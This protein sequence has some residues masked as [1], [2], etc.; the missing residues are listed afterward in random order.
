MRFQWSFYIK[1]VVKYYLSFVFLLEGIPK[2][3]ASKACDATKFE[4]GYDLMGGDI[5]P[6]GSGFR[7]A[8]SPEDCCNLCL[9]TKSCN[10]FTYAPRPTP[11]VAGFYKHNCWLKSS[12]GSLERNSDRISGSCEGPM[13]PAP[14][15]PAPTPDACFPHPTQPWC[16]VSLSFEARVEALINAMTTS[17]KVQQVS[18][19]TPSTVPGISRIGLPPYSYHSEGLHGLRD[20]V[21]TVGVPC[22]IFPQTTGMAATGNLSLIFAMGGIMLTEARALANDAENKSLGPFG[23]GAGLFYWSPTMNLGR[24]PRWGRFQESISED[25]FLNGIYSAIFVQAF[26]GSKTFGQPSQDKYL[27]VAAT[28]KHFIAYSLEASDGFSRHTFDAKVPWRDMVETYLPPFRMCISHGQP[29]QIMCSYNSI[30]GTPSCLH[31]DLLN[32]IARGKW[33]FDGL[34]VSDQDSISDSYKTH[35][36]CH[37]SGPNASALAI[38]A[39]CDQND[40]VTY[41]QNLEAALNQGLLSEKEL[42][43][44]L[45]RIL[46][47]RF[48]VGAFDPSNVV[49]P[50][51]NIGL[52]QVA[53]AS[54]MATSL[55]AAREAIVLLANKD[56]ILPFTKQKDVKIA[57]IGPFANYS[58]ALYGGKPDYGSPFTINILQGLQNLSFTSNVIY[59]EGCD[60]SKHLGPDAIEKATSAAAEADVTVIALGIDIT[61]EHEGIDRTNISL[62]KAQEAL[63]QAVQSATSRPVVVVLINGGPL[64]SDWIKT[65]SNSKPNLAAIEAFEL[66]PYAGQAVAEVLFGDVNP[67]GMLPFTVF[68]ENYT[69][70]VNMTDMTMRNTEGLGRTYRFYRDT[71]LWPFGHFMSYTTFSVKLHAEDLNVTASEAANISVSATVTNTGDREGAMPVQFYIWFVDVDGLGDPPVKALWSVAKVSLQQGESKEVSASTAD[72]NWCPFCTVDDFGNRAIRPGKYK[73]QVGGDG[74]HNIDEADTQ[75]AVL[76]V[77]VTGNQIEMPL[78]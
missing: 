9:A 67:S 74:S 34:I 73:I 48:R 51:R 55:Q 31:G 56:S 26:Q 28:C 13:P 71:P 20:S 4:F 17:E 45:S 1:I 15:G 3:G 63:L 38:Q 14:P 32:G 47:Q 19:F 50:L 62:P 70:V 44:A 30:N 25:P 66:G 41:A 64:S 27:G 7:N 72:W 23:K 39:G 35:H 78:I 12:T 77:Q 11:D 57:V 10:H 40:G 58:A 18:T 68:P 33:G 59:A 8:S 37:N 52:D 43:V 24:D 42:D 49:G 16:N 53:T 6:L 69:D 5:Q 22:T 60:V 54:S 46:M 36:C 65:A 75:Q 29:G 21:E 76:N 61:I 2:V